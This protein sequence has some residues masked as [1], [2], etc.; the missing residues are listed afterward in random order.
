MGTVTSC[1]ADRSGFD[2]E[3]SAAPADLIKTCHA[4]PLLADCRAFYDTN[5]TTMYGVVAGLYRPWPVSHHEQVGVSEEKWNQ[6]LA[7]LLDFYDTAEPGTPVPSSREIHKLTGVNRMVCSLAVKE[8]E[9]RGLITAP[10]ATFPRHARYTL[11]VPG[12]DLEEAAAS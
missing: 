10:S 6:V 7:W 11:P 9:A 8:M 2:L 1:M 12:A 3:R 5:Q 4:C